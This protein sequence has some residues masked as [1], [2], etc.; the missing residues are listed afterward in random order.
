MTRKHI[1][2]ARQ[3]SVTV[4]VRI[5]CVRP[6]ILAHIKRAAIT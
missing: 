2:G 3:R 5:D 6:G 4:A 1:T